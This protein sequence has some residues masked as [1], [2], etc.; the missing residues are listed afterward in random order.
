MALRE[1]F[2]DLWRMARGTAP[3][4]PLVTDRIARLVPTFQQGKAVKK[5]FDAVAYGD[6]AYRRNAIIGACI[7]EILSTVPQAKLVASQVLKD[8]TTQPLPPDHGLVKLLNKPNPEYSQAEFIERLVLNAQICGEWYVQ[9]TRDKGGFALAELWPLRPDRVAPVPGDKP[10]NKGLI[11]TYQYTISGVDK[12]SLNTSDVIRCIVRPDFINEYAALSPISSIASWVKM[13]N[14]ATQYL[15]DYFANS[16]QPAGY[17]KFKMFTQPQDRERARQIWAERHGRGDPNGLSN[18]HKTGVLDQDVEYIETGDTPGKIRLDNIFDESEC[19]ICAA[20]GVHP[21][22]I[23]MRIGLAQMSY[24]NADYARR[25]LWEEK[26]LPLY[27]K[28]GDK[29]TVGLAQPEFGDNLII[30]FDTSDVTALQ[31]DQAAADEFTL[32]EWT[33]KLRTR[34]ETLQALGYPPL[35]TQAGDEYYEPRPLDAGQIPAAKEGYARDYKLIP[36]VRR[37]HGRHAKAKVRKASA[38]QRK[39]QKRMKA[40]FNGQGAA[41]A[42]FLEK[43]IAKVK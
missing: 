43:K 20:F 7:D 21:I 22:L 23:A 6:E 8:G 28:I 38:A 1:Y 16:A 14:E 10:E 24:A 32:T 27:R 40:H 36:A 33:S 13:D 5:D 12:V 29:L 17:L 39:I 19:R 25:S 30:G 11:A 41:L 35:T 4:P 42:T 15:M 18:W 2:S 31:E 26:L 34:N 3:A 9:K 37:P